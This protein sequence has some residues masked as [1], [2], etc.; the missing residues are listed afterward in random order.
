VDVADPG[1][2]NAGDDDLS[3]S[4]TMIAAKYRVEP[5]KTSRRTLVA[6]VRR[7]TKVSL[8][9]RRAVA[10]VANI[11]GDPAGL[12]DRLGIDG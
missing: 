2:G 10:Q 6:T 12:A 4:N 8:R 7:L 3:D 1:T 11:L 5:R 9:L